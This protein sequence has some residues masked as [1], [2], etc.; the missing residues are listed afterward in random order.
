M[1]ISLRR[2]K[3]SPKESKVEDQSIEHFLF[4][5]IQIGL[6][7]SIRGILETISNEYFG[8][9]KFFKQESIMGQKIVRLIQL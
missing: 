6:Q 2:Y 9:G 8:F 3:V 4:E 1:L 7:N 5:F